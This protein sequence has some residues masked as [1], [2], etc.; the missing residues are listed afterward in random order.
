MSTF[1]DKL[2]TSQ[3]DCIF[4]KSGENLHLNNP[5][6]TGSVDKVPAGRR[7][8]VAEMSRSQTR[9]ARERLLDEYPALREVYNLV[10]AVASW[11]D[12]PKVD[13]YIGVQRAD[14][15]LMFWQGSQ[16]GVEEFSDGSE[17]THLQG[18]RYVKRSEVFMYDVGGQEVYGRLYNSELPNSSVFL[19]QRFNHIV[20]DQLACVIIVNYELWFD[21]QPAGDRFRYHKLNGGKLVEGRFEFTLYKT[22]RE[23]WVK[24]ATRAS[25]FHDV[26]LKGGELVTQ[27][28]FDAH[29]YRE[30]VAI[31]GEQ[32]HKFDGLAWRRGLQAVPRPLRAM[33]GDVRVLVTDDDRPRIQLERRKTRLVMVSYPASVSETARPILGASYIDGTLDELDLMLNDAIAWWLT[34]DDEA[35]R[36]AFGA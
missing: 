12:L 22:P 3:I 16:S 1:F 29:W 15:D 10:T 19:R 33:F 21:S 23:G 14:P 7:R 27:P 11:V 13:I 4:T 6:N 25:L 9:R 30:L 24:L 8:E 32:A 34:A 36:K 5:S 31:L 35:R 2:T 28:D 20:P 26:R 17:P 18:L